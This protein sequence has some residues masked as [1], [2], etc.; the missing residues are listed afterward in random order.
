MEK[1]LDHAESPATP[2]A[3]ADAA[4]QTPTP[5]QALAI[6]HANNIAQFVPW[7]LDPRTLP[8]QVLRLEIKRLQSGWL[9]L[10]C[11]LAQPIPI[12]T[13]EDVRIQC[14]AN[15]CTLNAFVKGHRCQSFQLCDDLEP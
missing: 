15:G 10:Y 9:R 5:Q 6:E 2:E 12:Q 1:V 4:A 8:A 11:S 14:A 3:A 13:L 7:L